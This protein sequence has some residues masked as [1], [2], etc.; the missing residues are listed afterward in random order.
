CAKTHF[1]AVFK[2]HFLH[3]IIATELSAIEKCSVSAAKVPQVKGSVLEFDYRVS[4]GHRVLGNDNVIAALVPPNLNK[5]FRQRVHFFPSMAA[6]I[7]KVCFNGWLLHC[8][9][10][11]PT[12]EPDQ[13]QRQHQSE[14]Q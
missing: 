14:A 4:R 5:D 11:C 10:F 1:V 8:C 12:A 2:Y 9:R 7:E 13:K 3:R 6:D